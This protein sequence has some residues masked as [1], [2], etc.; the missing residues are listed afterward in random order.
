M[1]EIVIQS[2][3]KSVKKEIMKNAKNA[4]MIIGMKAEGYAK[5]LA[6]VDTGLLR[7][8]I[9]FA[10]GGEQTSVADY[11]DDSGSVVG[12]YNGVPPDDGGDRVTVYVGTNVH[13]APYLELGHHTV[14]GDWVDARP[15][16]RPS[17]EG[18]EDEYK[19][20]IEKE[21]LK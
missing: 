17:M 8:S 11:T 15:F 5:S 6:P 21:L 9:T 18:H 7:N 3:A 20:I 2:H 10:L 14:S 16:L 1:G 13:Y 12:S 4:L 19:K